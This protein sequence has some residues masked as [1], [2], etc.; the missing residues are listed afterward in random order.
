MTGAL[1]GRAWPEADRLFRSDPSWVGGDGSHSIA[2]GAD[3]V[4]WIHADTFIA[5]KPGTGRTTDST[6]INNSVGVQEGLDPSRATMHFRWRSR[7]DGRPAAFFEEPGPG[8]LWP[9]NGAIL[10]G[11]LLLFAMRVRARE[12]SAEERETQA[13]L[14]SFEVYDWVAILVDNPAEDP[15][16]WRVRYL[17]HADSRF[18]TTIGAGSLLVEG[19][20]VY[21]HA[22]A[23]GKGQ[24]L[25]RWPVDQVSAGQ[26]SL[27]QWW[28]GDD[29]GWLPEPHCDNPPEPTVAE[30]QVEFTVHRDG[31][32]G[33]LVWVQTLGIV[34]A[35]IGV[36]TADR[37]EGRGRSSDR[38]SIR[39]RAMPTVASSTA[40][41]PT[42]NCVAPGTT[43]C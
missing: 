41:R 8:Y 4:I 37:L 10:D 27:P 26:L 13:A 23:R 12:M 39:R 25:A 24:Y 38:C 33:S 34:E 7:P 17:D 9:C 19:D 6:M 31:A 28:C 40:R 21:A 15:D 29:R 18:A 36:R 22:T 1:P 11:R 3:R 32:T 2:L 35:D 5:A 30:P 20:Y 14:A 43:W 42:R 16:G